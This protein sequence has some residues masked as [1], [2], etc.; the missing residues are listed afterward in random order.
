MAY[1]IDE[2]L[3]ATVT[4]YRDRLTEASRRPGPA[5]MASIFA[6]IGLTEIIHAAQ[7]GIPISVI[8]TTNSQSRSFSA[9]PFC[10][11]RNS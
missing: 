11:G 3:A 9:R 7:L 10:G 5:E 4:W 6:S 1:A 2:A 8:L